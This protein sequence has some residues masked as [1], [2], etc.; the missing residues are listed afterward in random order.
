MRL[1]YT[2]TGEPVKFGDTVSLLRGERAIVEFFTVNYLQESEGKVSVRDADAPDGSLTQEYPVS[3]IGAK[4]I[5]HEDQ[6][7]LR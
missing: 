5:E 6:P 7:S 2:A 1:I 3:A 4:W